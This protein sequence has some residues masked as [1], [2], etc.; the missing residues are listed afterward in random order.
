MRNGAA[1]LMPMYSTPQYIR[2]PNAPAV[3]SIQE[4]T[5][6]RPSIGLDLTE[7]VIMHVIAEKATMMA[8]VMEK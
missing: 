8:I 4:R 2:S 1:I 7:S 6:N 5:P 3:P